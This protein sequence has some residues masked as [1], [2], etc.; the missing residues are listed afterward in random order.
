MRTRRRMRTAWLSATENI[1]ELVA[2]MVGNHL[3]PQRGEG[4]ADDA[5]L[6][7]GVVD[8]E[9][10]I[11]EPLQT[12]GLPNSEAAMLTVVQETATTRVVEVRRDRASEPAPMEA[13]VRLRVVATM[14]G[15]FR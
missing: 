9:K 2:D 7:T 10:V 11:A 4:V 5:L 6:P 1:F 8:E 12:S 13:G 3:G 15:R 14:V